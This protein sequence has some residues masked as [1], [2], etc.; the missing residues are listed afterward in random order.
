MRHWNVVWRGEPAKP[1]SIGRLDAGSGDD[2]S[3]VSGVTA[4][5]VITRVATSA[6]PA[7]SYC[8]AVTRYVPSSSLSIACVVQRPVAGST[9]A[10]AVSEAV[11]VGSAVP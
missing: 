10:S 11:S 6:L 8:L 2:V 3:R 1:N 9:G 4:L 5:V 7:W